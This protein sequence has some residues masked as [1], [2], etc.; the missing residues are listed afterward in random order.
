M[1]GLSATRRREHHHSIDSGSHSHG[2]VTSIH[3]SRS[4]RCE[5]IEPSTLFGNAEASWACFPERV[6]ESLFPVCRTTRRKEKASRV[7]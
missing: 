4:E 3:A 2:R 1:I 7:L 6:L 5:S